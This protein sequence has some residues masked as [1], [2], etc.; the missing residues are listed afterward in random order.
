M[1]ESLSPIVVIPARL[2][3][4]RLPNKPLADIHG[5][6]MIVHVW[7]RAVEAAIGPVLVACAEEEVAEAVRKAGGEAVLT[8]PDL[9][10]GSDRV[11]QALER[12]DP[13]GR[14]TA[15]VNVQGDLPTIDPG[16]IR[17]V[18]EPLA[19]P[20]VDMSTLV[21]EITVEEERTNPNVV[22]AVVG[23]APGQRTGRALYFTRATAPWGEG[24]HYHHIGLYAF[25]RDSLKRFV[26]LPQ[27]ILE[28]REKLE[29]LRA[30]ENGMRIDAALV[31]TI[32]LGVDTSADL[33]RARA[34]LAP[35]SRS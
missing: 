19:D 1:A 29:Q 11:S 34:L 32:P 16:I 22:K 10:S 28:Q 14:Y 6:A 35:S 30:L 18:F 3:A 4:T 31:D 20:A 27:G 24:P 2:K 5:E 9:P 8:D 26:A 13:E 23:L 17:A 15:V 33:D 21:T 7:R 25:R 12:F